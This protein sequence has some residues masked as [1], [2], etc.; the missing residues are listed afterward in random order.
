MES[1]LLLTTG[2]FKVNTIWKL[3]VVTLNIVWIFVF[4]VVLQK[5]C[6]QIQGKIDVVDEERYDC[7]AKV[8]KNN[9]DVCHAP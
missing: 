9:K 8:I 4:A 7:E 2:A 6:K 3:F 5:L 1:L